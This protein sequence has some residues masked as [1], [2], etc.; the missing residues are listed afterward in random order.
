MSK[1]AI[2]IDQVASD[3][4]TATHPGEI[5]RDELTGLIG[6]LSLTAAFPRAASTP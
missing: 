4:L 3:G 5:P 6:G 2:T 1:S